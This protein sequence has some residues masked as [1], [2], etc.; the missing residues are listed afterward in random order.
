MGFENREYSQEDWNPTPRGETNVTKW[1]VILTVIVF[2]L[3]ILSKNAFSPAL[4]LRPAAVFQG[5]V[6]QL[7]TYAVTFNLEE[8]LPVVFSSLIIWRFG[9]ELERMYGSGEI[10]A[11]YLGMALVV[12]LV[13]VACGLALRLP[14]ISGSYPIALGAM[15]LFATHF[16][17]ME[18]CILPAIC[19]QLRWLVAIYAL[20]G[21]YPALL[22]IQDGAVLQGLAVLSMVLTIP[23]AVAYRRF[24][25]HL[26]SVGQFLSLERVRR[27]WRTRAA[28]QRLRV[29][30][31]VGDAANTDEKVDAILA[32]IHEH[33]SESL[34]EAEREFLKRASERYK[35][36]T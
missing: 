5:Q 9:T 31:P 22:A 16:P 29:Y 25:W 8:I 27:A 3:Q 26:S 30:A 36:R 15:A 20:F 13:Y 4:S 33:G 10:G 34:T 1:F 17:R 28:R 32:K 18:V 7:L 6:W 23:F 19:I 2:V 21:M 11:I 14:A 24:H 35:N 12:S